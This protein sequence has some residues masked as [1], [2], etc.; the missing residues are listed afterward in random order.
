[1]EIRERVRHTHQFGL[2]DLVARPRHWS[3]TLIKI[4][5][6]FEGERERERSCCNKSDKK[7]CV[8]L[9]RKLID[10]ETRKWTKKREHSDNLHK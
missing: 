1:M 2:Y 6:A 7:F 9:P 3:T 10:E 4:V 8:D 5:A